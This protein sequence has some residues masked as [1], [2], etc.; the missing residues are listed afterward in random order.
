[1]KLSYLCIAYSTTPWLPWPS[2]QSHWCSGHGTTRYSYHSH[3]QQSK[4]QICELSSLPSTGPKQTYM[5]GM[6]HHHLL[7]SWNSWCL[8]YDIYS[9]AVNSRHPYRSQ[10]QAWA[11]SRTYRCPGNAQIDDRCHWVPLGHWIMVLLPKMYLLGLSWIVLTFE[12]H[13]QL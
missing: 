1:M 11:R 2:S 3:C 9:T 7:T 13:V 6:N 5:Q 12:K 10:A 4:G 8:V